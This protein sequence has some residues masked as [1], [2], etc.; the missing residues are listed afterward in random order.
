MQARRPDTVANFAPKMLRSH[1]PMVRPPDSTRSVPN[2]FHLETGELILG[3]D[4]SVC[5]EEPIASQQDDCIR[6][7]EMLV[8]MF[9]E[10]T[11]A[12][13]E[14]GPLQQMNNSA[15]HVG[16]NMASVRNPAN[17]PLQVK[18]EFRSLDVVSLPSQ[19]PDPQAE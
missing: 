15:V 3:L 11:N 4:G 16:S 12:S 6:Q 8:K 9:G 7:A 17:M 2:N 18:P 10:N 13:Q 5:Y 14:V 19:Q 1:D